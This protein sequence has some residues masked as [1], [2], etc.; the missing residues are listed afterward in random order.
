MTTTTP[1]RSIMIEADSRSR[2]TLPGKAHR[3]YLVHEHEDGTVVLEPA[4]VLS[5]LEARYLANPQLQAIVERGR[6]NPAR[7][8]AVPERS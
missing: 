8:R 7:R 6:A 3:R 5:E 2:L 4:V 1:A